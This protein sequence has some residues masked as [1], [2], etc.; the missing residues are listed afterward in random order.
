MPLMPLMPLPAPL[1]VP[2][3]S[4]KLIMGTLDK[5]DKEQNA[6]ELDLECAELTLDDRGNAERFARRFSDRVRFD[7]KTKRWLIH[8]G[9]DWRVDESDRVT[10]LAAKTARSIAR[11]AD[12]APDPIRREKLQNWNLRSESMRAIK[13]MLRHAKR[14]LS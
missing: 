5:M 9:R 14:L 4:P 1:L 3:T 13:A 12:V 11:E 7:C 10:H 2:L 6:R 8:D